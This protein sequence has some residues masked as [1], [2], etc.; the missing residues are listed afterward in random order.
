M[1]NEVNYQVRLFYL[2]GENCEIKFN[3]IFSKYVFL[4]L[5]SPLLPPSSP[6]TAKETLHRYN[7]LDLK[8]HQQR[9]ATKNRS[10]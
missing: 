2:V 10:L 3:Y 4:P 5:P 7:G 8:S 9:Y 6:N 1:F